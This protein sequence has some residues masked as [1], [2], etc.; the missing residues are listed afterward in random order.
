MVVNE[1]RARAEDVSG[2]MK[3]L[4]HPTRLLI[5]CLLVENEQSVG[6]L[7]AAV[8]VREP[9]MSQQLAMLRQMGLVATRREAQTIY[10]QIARKDVR[11]VMNFLYQTYCAPSAARSRKARK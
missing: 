11:E 4:S 7:A 8:G 5:L 10:Y 2:L 6:E 3:V 9:A 1:M